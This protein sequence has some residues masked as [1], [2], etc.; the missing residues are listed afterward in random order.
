[1]GVDEEGD[2]TFF[3]KSVGSEE[4]GEEEIIPPRDRPP[5]PTEDAR[6]PVTVRPRGE[7]LE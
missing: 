1:M 2:T 7:R 5:T 6:P 3:R 4:M